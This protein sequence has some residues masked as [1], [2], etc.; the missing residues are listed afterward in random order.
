MNFLRI[1]NILN[2]LLDIGITFQMLICLLNKFAIN[3]NYLLFIF[4][5]LIMDLLFFSIFATFNNFSKVFS[6][7][8]LII[9][10]RQ[11]LAQF[12]LILENRN[13]ILFLNCK[14]L[15]FELLLIWIKIQL[16]DFILLSKIIRRK[17]CL[18]LVFRLPRIGLKFFRIIILVILNS[19]IWWIILFIFKFNLLINNL[20]EKI[21]ILF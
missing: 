16:F 5:I 21:K 11:V 8:C 12:W 6:Y 13:T 4:R 1:L 10:W 7:F 19:F 9:F 18:L 17:S 3:N 15:N 20:I 2:R 14:R